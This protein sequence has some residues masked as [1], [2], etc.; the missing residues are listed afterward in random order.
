[1]TDRLTD[2]GIAMQQ[3]AREMTLD[4]WCAKLPHIH[5]VNKQLRRLHAIE[6]AARAISEAWPDSGVSLVPGIIAL[7]A[8][9]DGS[10]G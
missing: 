4:E 8:A 10:G 7:R 5:L 6:A 9:L 2:A 3:A 1:M